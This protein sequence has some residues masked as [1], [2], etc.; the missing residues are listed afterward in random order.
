MCCNCGIKSNNIVKDSKRIS[1]TK[2]I[3]DEYTWKQIS[4]PSHKKNWK[5]C[6]LN[7]KSITLNIL[8]V[9]YNT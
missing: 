2:P 5:K 7:N 3:I 1:K 4:F 6:E 9:P 8:Y